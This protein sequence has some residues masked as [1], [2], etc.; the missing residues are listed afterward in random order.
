MTDQGDTE[1]FLAAP[2][3]FRAFRP[4]EPVEVYTR[5]L[6]H[7][8]QE[9]CTYFV[10]FRTADSLPKP[11]RDALAARRA[12]WDEAHPPPHSEEQME[13]RA[14]V[15]SDLEEQWLDAGH[16]A[17]PFALRAPRDLLEAALK[18]AGAKEARTV[19]YVCMPN[20]VHALLIPLEGKRLED[21]LKLIK[22]RSS[23][24]VNRAL[25]QSGSLWFREGFDRIVRNRQH[26]WRCLQYIGAIRA[27]L[28]CG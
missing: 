10:T 11:A 24:Q 18:N 15:L 12:A 2:P 26:L 27:R 21:A 16:G 7:W 19:A 17:C 3:W 8:R 23:F 14:R 4:D 5:T 13:E 25:G 9:G 22:G 6:P 20:H 1:F 28:G